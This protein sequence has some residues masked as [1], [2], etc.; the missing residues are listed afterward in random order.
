MPV[1]RNVHKKEKRLHESILKS[2]WRELSYRN[3]AGRRQAAR[4]EMP[5]GVDESGAP[6][7]QRC[8]LKPRDVR[9]RAWN[10][11]PRAQRMRCA[12][13]QPALIAS[14]ACT[15]TTAFEYQR[16]IGRNNWAE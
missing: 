13:N 4:R 7:S 12:A 14:L 3:P 2:E 6:S 10:T 16:T 1:K 9:V 11:A 15:V 8:G 5:R